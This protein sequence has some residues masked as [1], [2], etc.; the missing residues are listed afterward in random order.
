[1]PQGI[2]EGL[3]A[4]GKVMHRADRSVGESQLQRDRVAARSTHGIATEPSD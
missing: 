1:M 3:A 4:I 2:G